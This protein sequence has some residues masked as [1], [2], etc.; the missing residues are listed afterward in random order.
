MERL[1][2]DIYIVLTTRGRIDGQKTLTR[3]HPDV[4]KAVCIYCHPGEKE[5][6]ER[7]WGGKVRLIEEY[8]KSC[9][10]LSE[11]R[12][13]LAWNA[14]KHKIIF[15]DD[16]VSF[17]VRML[18]KYKTP[19]VL[20][21]DNFTAEEIRFHQIQMFNFLWDVLDV[22]NIAISAPSFRPFNRD[23]MPDDEFNKR[24]FAVWGLDTRKYYRKQNDLFMSEY[25]IKQDFVTGIAIR[26]MGYDILITNRWSFD[27]LNGSNSQGGCSHYRTIDMMNNVAKSMAERF[28]GIIKIKRRNNKNWHG[29][30]EGKEMLDVIV[31]WSKIKKEI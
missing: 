8:D 20:N 27:K 19:R 3:L 11:V 29:E 28:P 18:G 10:N 17:S 31:N 7:N 16:N 1:R 9:T 2:K 6:H 21:E 15:V 26:R 5:A 23:N 30:M 24:F 25:P 12:E 22:E 13:W 4:R 14:P